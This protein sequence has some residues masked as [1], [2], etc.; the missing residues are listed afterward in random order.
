[1]IN[2]GWW[3]IETSSQRWRLS[4]DL[5]EQKPFGMDQA[6]QA[7]GTRETELGAREVSLP[8]THLSFTQLQSALLG[9]LRHLF[10]TL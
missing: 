5:E 6:L 8:D 4:A 1:M 7:E 9:N 3:G 10:S 2:Q